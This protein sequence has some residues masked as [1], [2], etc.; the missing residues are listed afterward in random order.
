M[1]WVILERREDSWIVR[2]NRQ[3]EGSVWT[4][5]HPSHGSGAAALVLRERQAVPSLLW[6]LELSKAQMQVD[7]GFLQSVDRFTAHC[8]SSG[9]RQWSYRADQP[10]R[11]A[12]AMRLRLAELGQPVARRRGDSIGPALA[13]TAAAFVALFAWIWTVLAIFP[14]RTVCPPVGDILFAVY[15]ERSNRTRDLM[16]PMT[17][18]RPGQAYLVLGRSRRRLSALAGDLGLSTDKVVLFRPGSWSAAARSCKTLPQLLADGANCIHR[19]QAVPPWRELVAMNFRMLMGQCYAEWWRSARPGPKLAV[20]SHSGLADSTALERA[21]QEAGTRTA[22]LVHGISEG[23][24]F[25]AASNVGIFKCGFDADW[26]STLPCYG[27]TMSIPQPRPDLNTGGNGWVIC[28]NYIHPMNPHFR[29][30]GPEQELRILELVAEVASLVKNKPKRITWKPHP[31]FSTVQPTIQDT[32][33]ERVAFHG[34]ERWGPQ[35]DKEGLGSYR[36]ILSTPSTLALDALRLGKLPI[37]ISG[38]D[39]R[40][41]NVVG[42]FPLSGLAPA[43]LKGRIERFENLAL[44]EEDFIKTWSRVSPGAAFS[45]EWLEALLRGAPPPHSARSRYKAA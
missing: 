33:L 27:T 11:F 42:A 20:F 7:A 40:P 4:G 32:V 36:L 24:N 17:E 10:R 29:R 12:R 5:A 35:E 18:P 2:T 39:L 14:R 21:Q 1:S 38:G 34:F 37:V 45:Q 22:H 44:L 8:I 16:P 15:G 3:S 43:E 25:T 23:W 26:H 9:Q 19:C 6:F 30:H 41:D 31:V 13:F 28:T